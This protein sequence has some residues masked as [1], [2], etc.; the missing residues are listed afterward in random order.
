MISRA[1]GAQQDVP[2]GE[3]FDPSSEISYFRPSAQSFRPRMA[4]TQRSS[5]LREVGDGAG[6][7][8]LA[9]APTILVNGKVLTRF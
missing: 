8:L 1:V 6:A 7:H 4:E 9:R 3:G 2:I 5:Y